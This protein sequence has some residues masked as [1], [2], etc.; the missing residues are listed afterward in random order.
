MESLFPNDRYALVLD[1]A[2][3]ES[4]LVPTLTA[5]RK[6]VGEGRVVAVV[7]SVGSRG[8]ERRASI[9][10]TIAAFCDLAVLTEDNADFEPVEEITA[11]IASSFSPDFPFLSVPKREDAIRCALRQECDAIIF[12]GKGDEPFQRRRAQEHPYSERLAIFEAWE[13]LEKEPNFC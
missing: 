3:D 5:L 10:K 13:E 6:T 1:D 12:L 9:A 8:E 7:G 11:E 2:Y 4:R